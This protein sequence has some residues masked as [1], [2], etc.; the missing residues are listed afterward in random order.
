MY[1]HVDV[2]VYVYVYVYMYVCVCV[3]CIY[4]I[5]YHPMYPCT[6]VASTLPPKVSYKGPSLYADSIGLGYPK[7]TPLKP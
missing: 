3:F 4:L 2:Y 6:Q 7:P 1:I 5:R